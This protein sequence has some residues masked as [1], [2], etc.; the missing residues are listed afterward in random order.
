VRLRGGGLLALW[1]ATG[2]GHAVAAPTL[3]DQGRYLATA[4]DCISCHTR[5]NG[6]P[7]AGGRALNTPFGV[8]YSANVTP[9]ATGIGRWTEQQFARALREGIAAD[10]SH[11]YPAFPYTAY[12][13]V[14]DADVHALYAYF[15]SLAPVRYSP[16]KNDMPFPFGVRAL[17]APWNALFFD[18]GVFVPD[19]AKSGEWNRGAYLTQGLGHC[20]ACHTPRNLLGGERPV[21][22]LSGGDYLDDVVDEVVEDN[23]IP[24]D[25]PTVRVWAA[26]N[27]TPAR[28]GLGAWSLEAIVGYLKTGHSARAAAFGPMSEVVTNS[29]SHLTDAD[30]RAIAVYLKTLPPQTHDT[31]APAAARLRAGEIV[32]TARCADCHLPTGL[33]IARSGDADASKTA[34]PLAGSAAVQA[35]SPATLINVILYGAHENTASTSAWPSMSGF[36]LAVGLDDE[37]I[38]A[39]ATYVRSSWGN[40][41]SAVSAADVARQH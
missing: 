14:T 10:G 1:L 36:E 40:R 32:F 26:A 34:P 16:P 3:I 27:L 7:F 12:T 11:L 22:A 13:K 20:G 5:A 17:L 9:D 30:L 31:P 39:L 25:E 6:P 4:G 28:G 18:G 33:G 8:I 35:P 21:L 24:L 2:I 37:Q 15:R 38:A 41:A 29:T 23:I 19:A